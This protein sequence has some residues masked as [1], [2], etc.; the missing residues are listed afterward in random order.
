M[1]ENTMYG[2]LQDLIADS[3]EIF[4][5][6]EAELMG[7]IQGDIN[8]IREVCEISKWSVS[9]DGVEKDFS[10]FLLELKDANNENNRQKCIESIAMLRVAIANIASAYSN[11][12]DSMED[13]VVKIRDHSDGEE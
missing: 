10:R 1:S 7:E 5:G 8:T 4:L 3:I 9:A 11:A 2:Q 6:D 13:V 12:M